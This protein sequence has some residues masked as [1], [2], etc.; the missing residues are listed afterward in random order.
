MKLYITLTGLFIDLINSRQKVIEM[1][2][3]DF[4]RKYLGSYLGLFWAFIHPLTMI[5]IYWFV[6]SV[7][8]KSSNINGV[9][10]IVWFIC[11]ITPWFFISDA[12]TNATGAIIEYSFLLKKMAFNI[13]MLPV[14]KILSAFIL[15]SFFILITLIIT[16]Y[17]IKPSV[18]NF[19]ILYY[20]LSSF[21][22]VTGVTFITSSIIVFMKDVGQIVA[23][24]LQLLFWCTPIV[25]QSK[26]I[27][28]NYEFLLVLNPIH[29]IVEGYRDSL[30]NHIWFWQ[31]PGITLYFWCITLIFLFMGFSLFRR[32]R[33]H[34][35]DVI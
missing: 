3:Q 13:G 23:I 31:R 21:A 7:G 5:A 34:F 14:V 20:L 27:P 10:F 11:G 33:P 15:N 32:L 16:Y 25:W 24:V 18:Y 29:Y 4:R 6:F 8:F 35:A 22:F 9:N 1:T 19:Q 26:I 28:Q 30:I 17:Y 2:R 12:I